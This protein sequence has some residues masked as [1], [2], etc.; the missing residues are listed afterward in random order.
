MITNS[1]ISN[2]MVG[3]G[4]PCAPKSASQSPGGAQ[5]TTAPARATRAVLWRA[6]FLAWGLLLAAAVPGFAQ[7]NAFTKLKIFTSPGGDSPTGPLARDGNVLFGC[8]LGG[9][10]LGVIFSVNTD[11]TGFQV[12]RNLSYNTDGTAPQGG[13]T[14][15][16]NV[17]YGVNNTGGTNGG[18]TLFSMHTDG[19]GFQVLRHFSS[20]TDGSSP[21]GGLTLAG[22]VLYGV[23]LTGGGNFPGGTLFAVN[24]DGTGFHV[25][26]RFSGATDGYYPQGGL[27]LAG[28]V[29][30]GVNNSGGTNGDG[31]LFSMHTDGTGFQVL[32]HFSSATDGGGPRGGLAL[33]GNVLYGATDHVGTD[34]YYGTLFAVNT[35]GT[36]FRVLRHFS[37]WDD[38]GRPQGGLTLVSNVLYGANYYGGT[39]TGGTL[40]SV[41]TD[42]TGFQVL[43]HF[44]KATDGLHPLGGLTLA[45]NVLYGASSFGG[46]YGYGTLFSV[47][48]DG[49]GFR[50]L[51]LLNPSPDGACPLGGLTLAGN[52][53][54]G[55]TSGDPNVPEVNG[56]TLF[57][58]NT[59][60]TGF[61]M[62][63]HFSKATDGT[64]P[65][66]GLT[67]ASNVLYGANYAGGTNDYG[68]LFSVNTDGTGFQVLRHFSY[69]TDGAWPVGR[70]TLVGNVLYGAN[71]LGGTNR[72]G[73]LF[74][75]NT[76]GTGFRVLRHLSND[77][78]GSCPQGG[79]TLAGNVLYGAN[80]NGGTNK[81]GTLFSVN[82]DGTGF[83]VLRHFSKATDGSWPR[84]GL[85]LAGNVLYGVNT[86]DGTNNNGTLFSMHT[87]GT[88]FRVLRHL[89]P[90]TDGSHPQG[91]LTLAGNV[92]YGVNTLGGTNDGGTLFAVS[93][94]GTGFRVLRSLN[95]ATDGSH[96]QGGLTLASNVLYGVARFGTVGGLGSIG[97]AFSGLGSVFRFDLSLL[98]LPFIT[99]APANLFAGSSGTAVFAVTATGP[100]LSYQWYFNGVPIA[101]ATNA[102]L[103][104]PHV[105]PNNA[106]SYSVTVSNANNTVVSSPALLSLFGDLKFNAGTAGT[107]LAGAIGQQ[108]RVDYADVVNVGTTNWQVLTN[109]ALPYSPYLV[110]D[111][112]SAGKA[113]RY[114]RAVPVP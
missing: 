41:N 12:L 36:G 84:G 18:G 92:L 27:T 100:N 53:L 113:Q 66:D 65:Y 88:G 93:T 110:I 71:S 30:Y 25:L 8:A 34:G 51:T 107:T 96:P 112:N 58:V 97:T 31:T 67:L 55:V 106:G 109:I 28:N 64:F 45:G 77:T 20:A 7:A 62:L 81:G 85:T 76:D 11:G 4:T 22:N 104:L 68:T 94:D 19:T 2:G 5:G 44:S 38:G 40:F 1:S 24:T 87:D 15:A 37:F 61:Q 90:A 16:G 14:L 102:T 3:R 6:L 43:R 74:S 17:L 63:K 95:P 23:T 103:T 35:D 86:Y 111:P 56:G 50:V 13:L 33:A 49:T 42:G 21:Q 114:Y 89:N 26:R 69:N 32:R 105:T 52:V 108:F 46:A 80:I 39:N 10:N 60:G 78:D 72:S 59:D 83:Q 47:N 73:T 82:T 9:T 48:T 54:Y 57:A 98:P 70:L 79:L 91:G 101:S 29:L 99:A 75:V